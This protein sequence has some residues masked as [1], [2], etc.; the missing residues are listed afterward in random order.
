M[1]N[2][3][4][5]NYQE[6]TEAIHFFGFECYM[7]Y[8]NR[9]KDWDSYRYD[10]PDW[11]R[12]WD[13]YLFEK[14]LSEIASFFES[15][16]WVIS[17]GTITNN[18]VAMCAMFDIFT[19]LKQYE[20]SMFC[21]YFSSLVA[22]DSSLPLQECLKG[23]RYRA[24]NFIKDMEGWR[25][26]CDLFL[27]LHNDL[28]IIYEGH[29]TNEFFDLSLLYDVYKAWRSGGAL[30]DNLKNQVP[31]IIANY[32]NYSKEKVLLEGEL[33]HK[34]MFEYIRSTIEEDVNNLQSS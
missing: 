26:R 12:K 27:A 9:I 24:Y 21:Y 18:S 23:N 7:V 31:R 34:A 32:P 6:I 15:N 1:I 25:S 11:F 2:K 4:L 28:N 14:T 3:L 20:A 16:N 8:F 33:A 19:C 30:L 10:H 13:K 29:L 22:D 17:P 5:K